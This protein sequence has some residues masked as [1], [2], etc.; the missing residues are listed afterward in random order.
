MLVFHDEDGDWQFLSRKEERADEI[1]HAH[2]GHLIDDDQ[3]LH[4]LADLPS[5]VEGMARV[6]RGR[7][8]TR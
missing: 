2:L 4:Q 8:G 6:G 7:L 1:V 3:T 5:W